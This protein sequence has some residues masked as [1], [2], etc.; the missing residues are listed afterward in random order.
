MR[1]DIKRKKYKMIYK[2]VDDMYCNKFMNIT[3]CCK[4]IRM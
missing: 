1:S 2:K 3:Q 4:E